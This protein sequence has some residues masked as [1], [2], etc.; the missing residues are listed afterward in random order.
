[1]SPAATADALSAGGREGACRE[2]RGRPRREPRAARR[3]GGENAA[4]RNDHSLL[5]AF[6]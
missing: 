3:T 2:P 6:F 4:G 1:M 5:N